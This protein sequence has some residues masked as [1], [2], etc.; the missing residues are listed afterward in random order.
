MKLA[1]ITDTHF[2]TRGDNAVLA[3]HHKRFYDEVFF[4][5]I[6]EQNIDTIIHLGDVTDRRKYI[7]YVT[8]KNLEETFMKPIHDRD[9]RLHVILGNHDCF[10][11]NTNEVNSMRQLY[12]TS[13]YSNMTVYENKPVKL[14]FDGCDIMLVPWISP[15]NQVASLK[16][17]YDTSAQ[18]LMGHFSIEGF[19]MNRGSF[20]DHGF[21]TEI[22]D[23]FDI[24]YSGHFHHPSTQGSISYLG[25]PYEMNWADF[26]GKRG[27]HIFDTD[28]RS[29]TFIPNPFK[30]FHKI[31]YNDD[32]LTI[33]KINQ[34]DLSEMENT[35]VKVIVGE[36]NNPYMFDLFLDALAKANCADI[37]VVDD[38]MNFADI[39]ED[40]LIDE[41]QDTLSIMSNYVGSL[42]TNVDK[43]Y[44]LEI[45]TELYNE[46]TSL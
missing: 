37:K 19:E 1:L 10:H 20:C 45:M 29:L 11:K 38:H 28:D 36:K 34:F 41:A 15:E 13:T 27:F 23:K 32:E 31:K 24:V 17:M 35:Y 9:I 6:D 12:G 4:P 42:E 5:T 26:D 14:N 43:E 46:A 16:A 33:D 3:A 7:N 40:D 39:D 2:G 8:A 22:F 44:V 25:A 30:I 18:V 21:K